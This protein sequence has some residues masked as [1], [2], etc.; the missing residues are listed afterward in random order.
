MRVRLEDEGLQVET[1]VLMGR[2]VARQ[3]TEVAVR[4]SCDLIM[5]A[6]HGA[7]GLD[8]LLMGS[9]T[10]QVVRRA[11]IPVLVLPPPTDVPTRGTQA[12]EATELVGA[13]PELRDRPADGSAG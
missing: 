1:R 2:K 5:M 7:G 11:T 6:T 12:E 9:V 8:R 3:I 13:G 4:E 10:D